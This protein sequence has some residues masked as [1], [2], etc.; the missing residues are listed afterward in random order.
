MDE[1]SKWL[2]EQIG[3]VVV[4]GLAIWWLAKRLVQAEKEKDKLSQ[5][6]IKLTTMWES[7]ASSMTD[8]LEEDKKRKDLI[9]GLLSE[10]KGMLTTKK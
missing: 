10:I 2:L 3:M 7:K 9:I 5:D 8:E 4:M 6:V 1:I